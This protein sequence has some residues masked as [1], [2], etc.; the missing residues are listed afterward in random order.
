M[1]YLDGNR[2]KYESD[3]VVSFYVRRSELQPCEQHLFSRYVRP[4]VTILDATIK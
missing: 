2:E 3:D 1:A 4:G